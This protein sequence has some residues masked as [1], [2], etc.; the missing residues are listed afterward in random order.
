MILESVGVEGGG[1]C[2]KGGI[3][4]E[5]WSCGKLFWS[6]SDWESDVSSIAFVVVE[7]HFEFK[8]ASV[9]WSGDGWKGEAL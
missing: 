9:L 3:E 6:D 2:F 1:G 4:R 7:P 5:G 8:I